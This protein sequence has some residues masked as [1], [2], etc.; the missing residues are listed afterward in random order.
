MQWGFQ[1]IWL[2]TNTDGKGESEAKLQRVLEKSTAPLLLQQ[3]FIKF[4]ILS[5]SKTRRFLGPDL[6]RGG[7]L[8]N[9]AHLASQQDTTNY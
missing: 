8:A 7:S 2:K 5:R 1:S 6:I 9:P 3:R 4:H